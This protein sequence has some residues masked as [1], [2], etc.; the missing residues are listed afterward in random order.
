[1]KTCITCNET[2]A[3]EDF[4][5]HNGRKDDRTSSCKIC[6]IKRAS[7]WVSEN[8][9][10]HR[11]RNMRAYAA[12]RSDRLAA[13]MKRYYANHDI[14]K[15]GRRKWRAENAERQA[16]A[17]KRW[18]VNNRT[19]VREI[20]RESEARRR[21]TE[22]SFT[23]QDIKDI[24]AMQGSRCAICRFDI[25]QGYH[26]DHIVPLSKGGTNY[27]RNIQLLCQPCNSRKQ[28]RDPIEH[29]QSLGFLL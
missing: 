1:M 7:Q 26:I 17:D 9:E 21:S 12:N 2:K 18:A 6:A 20:K 24:Y 15:A 23:T 28:A 8:Q 29:M 22:G 14:A 27:R 19:R 25:E 3:L 11:E 16:L 4:H 10:R 13:M 5:R